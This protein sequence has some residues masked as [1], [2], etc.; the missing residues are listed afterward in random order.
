MPQFTDELGR[1][2]SVEITYHTVCRVRSALKINLLEI[3]DSGAALVGRINEDLELL[4]DLL[5]VVCS[6]QA[7]RAAV[8]DELF[9]RGLA[10]DSFLHARAAL[11]EALV[12]FFP[13][14]KRELLRRIFQM[15]QALRTEL[16]TK[17]TRAIDE[18]ATR[19]P[20]LLRSVPSGEPPGSSAATPDPLPS[21][22]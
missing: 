13:P 12:N 17:S 19:L 4:V 10:G 8:D 9:G 16:E 18:L 14:P 2:W 20:A 3:L 22:S 5:W 21:A 11:E 7:E 6:E 15:G 1:D